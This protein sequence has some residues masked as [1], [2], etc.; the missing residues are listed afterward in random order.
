MA[1]G[2]PGADSSYAEVT[3][4]LV[5]EATTF[6]GETPVL[7][8]R[9]FATSG[10]VEYNPATEDQP[11]AQSGIRLLPIARRT[12]HVGGSE[13]EGGIDAIACVEDILV[14]FGVD[15]LASQGGEFLVFL[16]VEGDPASGSPSL[17]ISYYKGWA[18]TLIANSRSRTMNRVTLL[19]C[20]YARQGD[21]T[22]WNALV[23]ASRTGVYC[24]GAWVARYHSID[25]IETMP[26]WETGFL[27]PAV[28]LPCHIL[29][30]QYSENCLQNQIDCNQT[31]PNIDLEGALLSKL[32]LPPGTMAT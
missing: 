4:Q 17:S 29:L 27:T 32:I 23:Q 19:P 26:D 6:F 5:Q 9:Y 22:T 1:Q 2:K 3:D 15:Y 30:W 31:N 16:D 12:T 14:A 7:W 25:C 11:L 28:S 24:Y 20:V 18:N 13:Q 8:G 21:N 10:P